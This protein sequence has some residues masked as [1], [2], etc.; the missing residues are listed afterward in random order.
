MIG[1]FV[2]VLLLLNVVLALLVFFCQVLE[3]T[4]FPDTLA[5]EELHSG[6]EFIFVLTYALSALLSLPLFWLT[7]VLFLVWFHRAYKNLFAFN[8]QGLRTT[9]GWAVLLWFVP[10]LAFYYPFRSIQ[11]IHNGSDPDLEEGRTRFSDTSFSPLFV[12]WWGLWVLTSIVGNIT[13]RASWQAESD[14]TVR[15]LTFVEIFVAP[16]LIICGWLA[17]EIV[18]EITR[19][20]ELVG[21]QMVKANP[22]APPS[23][24]ELQNENI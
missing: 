2:R 1:N 6:G 17:Y 7:G 15:M 22:P 14:A 10:F 24:G 12:I 16:F 20:Q 5:S 19:R 8:V 9:P 21:G 18:T 3:V 11:E 13:F 4:L 23:F